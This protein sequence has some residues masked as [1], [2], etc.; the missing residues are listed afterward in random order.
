VRTDESERLFRLGPIA[1]LARDVPGSAE[2]AT[3]WLHTP[4]RALG[5]RVPL[6]QLDTDLGARQ[7]EDV[8]LRIAHGVHS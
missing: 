4:N 8:L 6:R 3:R 5:H 1:T 7:V 2:K